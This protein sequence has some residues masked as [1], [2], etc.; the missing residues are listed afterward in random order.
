M[1]SEGLWVDLFVKRHDCVGG[2]FEVLGDVES[3]ED[4]EEEELEE[5]FAGA[6]PVPELPAALAA[7]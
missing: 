4:A 5:L 7:H 1:T 3:D 2:R 6:I